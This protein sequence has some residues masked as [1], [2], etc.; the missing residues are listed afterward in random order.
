MRFR[1]LKATYVTNPHLS[2]TEPTRPHAGLQ[3][4][5][6]FGLAALSIACGVA[7]A[8]S[9][10][11]LCEQIAAGESAVIEALFG[12]LEEENVTPEQI[13]AL[14]LQE[15][16]TELQFVLDN[17][18]LFSVDEHPLRGV[19]LGT[20]IAPPASLD[21]CWA[22]VETERLP[23]DGSFEWLIA[24]A[25]RLNTAAG[26]LEEHIMK[27]VEGTPCFTDRRPIVQTF[28]ETILETDAVRVTVRTDNGLA[29]GLDDDGQLSFHELGIIGA[30]VSI[31]HERFFFFTV[32]GNYLITSEEQYDPAQPSD[33]DI[34]YWVRF[35]CP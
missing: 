19:G 33:E 5:A 13:E 29:A 15:I 10:S 14:T 27:G 26:T 3:L 24:E 16:P 23:G 4:A 21:G 35:D 2:H 8:P 7:C 6:L 22:R 31:E 17:R 25:W 28:E 1:R 20:V 9:P 30:A 12:F 34:D 11:T 18:E 32:E